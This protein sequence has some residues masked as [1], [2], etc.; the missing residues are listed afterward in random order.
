MNLVFLHPELLIL[1]AVLAVA[2]WFL[3]RTARKAL[4]SF[5]ILEFWPAETPHNAGREKSRADWPWVLI[6]AAAILAATALSAPRLQ[7][8]ES[9]TPAS[10]QG[11]SSSQRPQLAWKQSG[12]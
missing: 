6:L 1:P 2:G 10:S 3:L 7:I 8:A 5:T 4:Y 9:K 11:S 12:R